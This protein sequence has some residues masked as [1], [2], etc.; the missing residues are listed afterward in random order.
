MK[1]DRAYKYIS[2]KLSED[3]YIIYHCKPVKNH[4]LKTSDIFFIPFSLVWCGFVVFVI[5]AL[6]RTG[7]SV[8]SETSLILTL[9]LSI[10]LYIVFG[11]F[12]HVLYKRSRTFYFITNKKIIRLYR[13]F[14]SIIDGNDL[15]AMHVDSFSDGSGTIRFGDRINY[16]RSGAIYY[17][18]SMDSVENKRNLFAIEYVA[19]VALVKQK[20]DMMVNQ[21][22]EENKGLEYRDE[23]S[24]I[25]PYISGDEYILWKGK[26]EKGHY[27][28]KA[29]IILIPF[30]IFWSVMV[31]NFLISTVIYGV[32]FIVYIFFIPFIMGAFY[33][34]FARFIIISYINKRTLYVITNKK[35][36]R[37]RRN[38]I[39]II[40]SKNMP[41]MRVR[42]NRNGSGTIRFGDEFYYTSHGKLVGGYRGNP[43]GIGS[44]LLSLDNVSN[45][46]QV[47]RII[48][49]MD[50]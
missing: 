26:P 2:P 46:A 30:S 8:Q 24:F 39:D 35:I 38:K 40:D 33:F 29:D 22:F 25:N 50:K 6:M 1:L 48:D 19:D 32:P 10:G 17:E 34:L 44:K 49:S 43:W 31:F 11:R 12:I 28:T 4:L 18:S 3:E 37:L 23:Y 5:V 47:Q 14:I 20:I 27:F 36:I 21:D 16:R 9:F 15:P 13:K 42:V 41:A 45:I 7:N